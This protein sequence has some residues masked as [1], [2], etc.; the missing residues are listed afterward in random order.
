M[1]DSVQRTVEV[2]RL[3]N[4][5]QGFGWLKVKE[6]VIGKKVVITVEKELLSAA[7]IVGSGEPD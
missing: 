4:L 5:V 2:E 6:E 7:E 3:V 1:V